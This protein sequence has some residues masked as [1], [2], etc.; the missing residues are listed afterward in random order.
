MD[1]ETVP[2]W[3]LAAAFIRDR[4]EP[5]GTMCMMFVPISRLIPWNSFHAR[6]KSLSSNVRVTQEL[7]EYTYT[8]CLIQQNEKCT[9][10]D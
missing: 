9:S 10:Q 2:P 8:V 3:L 4:F 5:H 6:H 7:I 1:F